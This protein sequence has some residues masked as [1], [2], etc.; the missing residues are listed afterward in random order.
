MTKSS[1]EYLDLAEEL[2]K[3][4]AQSQKN[5]LSA[6]LTKGNLDDFQ[7]QYP[8][9]RVR[10]FPPLKT[11]TLFMHQ[12]ISENKSCRNALISDARD[13]IA[14][15]HEPG[16]TDNGAY[17]KAR[18]RLT[19]ESIKAL[20]NQAGENLDGASPESWLWHDR[21]VVI[22]D[23]STLSMPDSLENQKAYPQPSG[24]KK[25]SEIQS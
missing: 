1:P 10:N 3:K 12:A 8:G 15:G 20:L 17:C 13:Q 19:E 24:Q 16:E 9:S 7:S 4:F 5:D 23:G 11:L 14:L 25:G 6:V 22:T 21:R 18:Q 2:L